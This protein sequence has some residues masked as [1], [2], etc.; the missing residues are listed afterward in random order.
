MLGGMS[1]HTFTH[2]GMSGIETFEKSTGFILEN[3]I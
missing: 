2:L 1:V 3:P